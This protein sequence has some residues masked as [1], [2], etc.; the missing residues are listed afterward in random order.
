MAK[1]DAALL[2]EL[3]AADHFLIA[4][5]TSDKS[6]YPVLLSTRPAAGP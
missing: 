5:W 3:A 6:E 4:T 1:D 2:L